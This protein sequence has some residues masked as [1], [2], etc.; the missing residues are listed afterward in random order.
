MSRSNK[1]ASPV[2]ALVAPS[3]AN[4]TQSKHRRDRRDEQPKGNTSSLQSD[5]SLSANEINEQ[6]RSFFAKD[7]V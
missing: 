3:H 4:I 6:I 7:P 1:F 5:H 2:S